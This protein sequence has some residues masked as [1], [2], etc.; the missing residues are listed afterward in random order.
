MKVLIKLDIKKIWN[1]KKQKKKNNNWS[2]KWFFK[3]LFIF[4][5]FKI[6]RKIFKN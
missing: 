3:K 1:L 4:K 2:I 6:A 5:D